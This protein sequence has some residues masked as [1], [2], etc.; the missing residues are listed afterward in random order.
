MKRLRF[1]ILILTL[2]IVVG[3]LLSACSEVIKTPGAQQAHTFPVDPLFK[4]FYLALGGEEILGPAISPV[5]VRDSVSLCQYTERV[6]MCHHPNASDV[7]RFS[8]YPLG[9]ELAISPASPTRET[10]IP[11]GARAVNGI[12]IYEKFVPLYDKLYGARYVGQPITELRINYNLQR[13][14]QFFENVGFYQ[15][16]NDSN[17]PVYLI[18]Y[19]AYFCGSKCSYRLDEYWSIVKSNMAQQPFAQS[20]S[21]IGGIA[22]FGAP[23]LQPTIGEDGYLEQVYSN[24]I[25][26]APEDNPSMVRLRPLP[27]MLGY[28]VHS[29]VQKVSHDQLVFYEIETGWGHNVPKPFDEFIAMHGG[30][31]LAGRPISEALL[32]EGSS[33]VQQCFENY[34]LIYDPAASESLKVRMAPL[35]EEYLQKF[36]AKQ[37]LVVEN[38][39]TPDRIALTSAV[40]KPALP[41]GEEQVVRMVVMQKE[42]RQPLDRVEA[43]L[44]INYPNQSPVTYT[45]P[46]TDETGLSIVTIP[47]NPRVEHGDRLTYQ[48]CLNLPSEQPICNMGSYLIWDIQ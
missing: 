23:L 18:P 9:K 12:V 17:G 44:T 40:D 28:P 22:V 14:E 4:E 38:I 30:P 8:L 33:L 19:G 20:L 25:F 35:G 39:F 32:V 34:C 27:L 26:Y 45:F 11:T 43:K 3:I 15:G 48:I 7:D 5:E 2:S 29:L 16:L 42:T 6:L 10:A 41:P 1:L 36:P 24:V 21:R 47:A 31:D 46:P 13:V 37:E